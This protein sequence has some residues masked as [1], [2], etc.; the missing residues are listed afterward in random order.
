MGVRLFRRAQSVWVSGFFVRAVR[1][2]FVLA[3]RRYA[4]REFLCNAPWDYKELLVSR[5]FAPKTA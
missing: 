2:F 1:G 4:A 3:G 5:I